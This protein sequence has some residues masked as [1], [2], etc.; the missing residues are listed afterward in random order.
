MAGLLEGK[1]NKKYKKFRNISICCIK[2]SKSTKT[3]KSKKVEGRNDDR[4]K[5]KLFWKRKEWKGRLYNIN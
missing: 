5:K 4:R 1:N 3:N 2:I